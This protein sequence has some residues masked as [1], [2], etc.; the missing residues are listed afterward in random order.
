M[1]D[2]FP[3]TAWQF[4][5]IS[6]RT[7]LFFLSLLKDSVFPVRQT[8]AATAGGSLALCTGNRAMRKKARPYG[9]D[10]WGQTQVNP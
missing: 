6:L 1:T 8:L 2:G 5:T 3:A 9:A 4:P 10:H 7:R